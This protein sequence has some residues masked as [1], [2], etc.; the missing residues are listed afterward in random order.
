MALFVSK[1]GAQRLGW[2]ALTVGASWLCQLESARA[3]SVRCTLYDDGW[4]TPDDVPCTPYYYSPQ[5]PIGV[6]GRSMPYPYP[7]PPMAGP[8]MPPMGMPGGPPFPPM[9]PSMGMPPPMGGPAPTGP[10]VGMPPSG[11]P[12]T[13][14]PPINRIEK[15]RRPF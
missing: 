14:Q 4:F 8:G 12:L 9:A 7:Q 6:M 10:V 2:V 1:R 11:G 5:P 13:G 15:P 3:Q